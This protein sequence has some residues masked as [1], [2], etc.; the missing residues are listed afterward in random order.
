M[1]EYGG[2]ILVIL[3]KPQ[4]DRRPRYRQRTHNADHGT[5]LRRHVQN[6]AHH[7]VFQQILLLERK[8]R[9]CNT[10]IRIRHGKPEIETVAGIEL[11]RLQTFQKCRLL[12]LRIRFRIKHMQ[13]QFAAGRRTEVAKKPL[14]ALRIFLHGLRHTRA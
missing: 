2:F 7:I 6:C 13:S 4:V 1:L 3:L 5:F 9:Q 12:I 14:D 11:E 8:L 10:A